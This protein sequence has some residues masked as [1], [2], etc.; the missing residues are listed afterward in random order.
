MKQKMVNSLAGKILKKGQKIS[1]FKLAEQLNLTPQDSQMIVSETYG[2]FPRQPPLLELP[3]QFSKID[4]LLKRAPFFL[5]N[6][7]KGL[8]AKNMVGPSVLNELPLFDVDS[9]TDTRVLNA[10]L[11]DYAFLTSMYL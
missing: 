10:L 7:E 9:L 6:G 4:D 1:E 3:E 8:L 2:F 5:P 11:R